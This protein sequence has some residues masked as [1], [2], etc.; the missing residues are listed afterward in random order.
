MP[1]Q[2]R[3][4]LDRN[5]LITHHADEG[6]AQF[7][8]HRDPS[9]AAAVTFRSSRRRLCDSNGVPTEVVNTKPCSSH[10]LLELDCIVPVIPGARHHPGVLDGTG[11]CLSPLAC[12]QGGTWRIPGE[13]R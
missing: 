2:P 13:V 9:P 5:P 11:S 3:D 12:A 1:S 6:R 7:L 8:R 4:L 10:S